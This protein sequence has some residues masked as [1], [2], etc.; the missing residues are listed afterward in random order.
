MRNALPIALL[1]VSALQ[2]VAQ[3]QRSSW[4][5]KNNGQE[6]AAYML[7]TTYYERGYMSAQVNHKRSG[8]ADVFVV[9]PGPVFRF[10]GIKVVGL[11]EKLAQQVLKDAPKTGEVYS[12]A[13]VN[14]WLAEGRKELSQSNIAPKFARQETGLD[15]GTATANVTVWFK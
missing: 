9:N 7:Q 15:H 6:Y 13:R 12:A 3:D 4:T 1:F 5:D 14:D 11:S 10:K 8:E 2:A